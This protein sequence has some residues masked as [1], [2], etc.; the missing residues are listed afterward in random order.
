MKYAV[1]AKVQFCWYKLFCAKSLRQHC[2]VDQAPCLL[3]PLPDMAESAQV[4]HVDTW[5]ILKVLQLFYLKG[6]VITTYQWP[7]AEEYF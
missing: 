5:N 2:C 3:I 7:G 1:L 4:C 6:I